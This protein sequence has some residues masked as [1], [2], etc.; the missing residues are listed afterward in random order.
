MADGI[1]HLTAEISDGILTIERTD[2]LPIDIIS[3]E[4]TAGNC[5]AIVE[6]GDTGDAVRALQCLL[7][8]DGHCGHLDTDGIFGSLTQTAL[9]IFQDRRG[10][11]A[12]GTCDFQTWNELIRSK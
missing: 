7:N 11:T 1:I 3:R 10:L 6:Y 12:T 5:C 2:G 9:T 8:V 4:Q